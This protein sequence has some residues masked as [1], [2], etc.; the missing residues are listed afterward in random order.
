MDQCVAAL[1]SPESRQLLMS[2]VDPATPGLAADVSFDRE[3]LMASRLAELARRD[4]SIEQRLLG[5]CTIPLSEKKRALLSKVIGYLA[6]PKLPSQDQ[7]D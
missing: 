6:R 2:F 7:S 4:T 5:L 1:D 3:E